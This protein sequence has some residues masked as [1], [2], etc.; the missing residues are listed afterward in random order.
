MRLLWVWLDLWHLR[1]LSSSRVIPKQSKTKRTCY[2]DCCCCGSTPGSAQGPLPAVLRRPHCAEDWPACRTVSISPV[3][4][5]LPLNLLTIMFWPPFWHSSKN[6]L[7][8]NSK[9]VWGPPSTGHLCPHQVLKQ[10]L[11]S[12]FH[13]IQTTN[14]LEVWEEF[15]A[16]I[17]CLLLHD[18]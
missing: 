9:A 14:S 16:W 1:C 12:D 11:T 2:W 3:Y 6:W 7:W 5:S 13:I 10:T 15:C 17:V 4:I 8:P 18:L